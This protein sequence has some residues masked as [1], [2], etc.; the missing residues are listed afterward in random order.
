MAT[1]R[2]LYHPAP[3]TNVGQRKAR[4][5]L[6]QGRLVSDSVS[7][8]NNN[9][10]RLVQGQLTEDVMD[11]TISP[12][13][14]VPK[15][16]EN[17]SPRPE[18]PSRCLD[19][20]D[21]D[22]EGSETSDVE[23]PQS[24]IV[25][26]ASHL[27]TSPNSAEVEVVVGY[28]NS[29]ARVVCHTPGKLEKSFRSEANRGYSSPRHQ[30]N[31]KHWAV[32]VDK[33]HKIQSPAGSSQRSLFHNEKDNLNKKRKELGQGDSGLKERSSAKSRGII[34]E[35]LVEDLGQSVDAIS[36]NS[37]AGTPSP[38][39]H[40]G[41]NSDVSHIKPWSGN[42]F[43]LSESAQP[44]PGYIS[45]PFTSAGETNREKFNSPSPAGSAKLEHKVAYPQPQFD[46]DSDTSVDKL[47]VKEKTSA[48]AQQ[49]NS[50]SETCSLDEYVTPSKGK[51][52][53][54]V[55]DSDIV[56]VSNRQNAN[57]S[58]KHKKKTTR[59]VP[60]RYMQTSMNK[61]VSATVLS[62]KSTDGPTQPVIKLNQSGSNK[63][64]RARHIGSKP[65]LRASKSGS[66]R[67]LASKNVRGTDSPRL[68][69]SQLARGNNQHETLVSFVR[70]ESPQVS[71]QEQLDCKTSTPTHDQLSHFPHDID[72][73]AIQSLSTMSI[74]MSTVGT[75]HQEVDRYDNRIESL[76]APQPKPVLKSMKANNEGS[77]TPS[78]LELDL[79]YTRYLQWAFLNSK[80]KKL[81]EEQEADA[82]AQLHG[83]WKLVECKREDSSAQEMDVTRL[84]RGNL[85]DEILDKTEQELTAVMSVIPQL[86]ED[87]S[88]LCSALDTT[89]HQLPTKDIYISQDQAERDLDEERLENALRESEQLLA[90]LSELTG[91]KVLPLSQY[92]DNIEAIDKNVV[93]TTKEI[94]ECQKELDTVQGLA[95]RLTSLYVQDMQT[96]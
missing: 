52:K 6:V 86:E 81:F 75:A 85:L 96:K 65:D 34:E 74:N 84:K 91:N 42:V 24:V 16:T 71:N 90:E 93:V 64:T 76:K 67:S 68:A 21:A 89:R 25:F 87:Y 35:I 50:E 4:K 29:P 22:F 94:S 12:M 59:I 19:L 7:S 57:V 73:S 26:D 62:S 49:E 44:S 39:R 32:K 17:M 33:V 66:G 69:T 1:K 10:S 2:N 46:E 36:L 83:L 37:H 60:S 40:A 30:E 92:L 9:G 45:L 82:I 77:Q 55:Q 43:T 61:T 56:I 58:S 38:P 8:S 70:S 15:V 31:V 3:K 53:P 13:K 28:E 23:A 88:R 48:Q 47:P 11:P 63:L 72:A 51:A 41:T 5:P 20:S 78:Q 95:T 27:G 14:Y 79:E 80:A 18:P 54:A